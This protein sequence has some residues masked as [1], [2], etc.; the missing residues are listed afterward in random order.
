MRDLGNDYRQ[1]SIDLDAAT[2]EHGLVYLHTFFI[3]FNHFDD[4]AIPLDGIAIDD[5]SVTGLAPG[6][7]DTDSCI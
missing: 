1:I 5:I 3:R 4:F 2:A 7:L 6:S